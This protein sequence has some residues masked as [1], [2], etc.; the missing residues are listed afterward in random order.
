MTTAVAHLAHP[1]ET[2]KSMSLRDHLCQYEQPF[3]WTPDIR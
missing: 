3:R 1:G 2:V